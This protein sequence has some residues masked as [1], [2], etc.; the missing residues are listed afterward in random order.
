MDGSDRKSVSSS[1][2]STHVIK[3]SSTSKPSASDENYQRYSENGANPPPTKHF[4]SPTISAASK[5]IAP[6]KKILT[7]RNEISDTRIQK[8]LNI[9]SKGTFSNPDINNSDDSLSVNDDSSPLPRPKFLRYKPNRG[10]EIILR[11]ENV[12]E[13]EKERSTTDEVTESEEVD[14]GEEGAEEEEEEEDEEEEEREGFC[15]RVLKLL[16][17]LVVLVLSTMCISSSNSPTYSQSTLQAM[18][19]LRD[20]YLKIHDRFLNSMNFKEIM[21]LLEGGNEYLDGNIIGLMKINQTVIYKGVEEEEEIVGEVYIGKVEEI[22]EFEFEDEKGDGKVYMGESVEILAGESEEVCDLETAKTGEAVDQML[23]N[24]ELE[25]TE[26]VEK[27]ELLLQDNQIPILTNVA[28][29]QEDE[30]AMAAVQE[31]SMGAGEGLEMVEYEMEKTENSTDKDGEVFM[32]EGMDSEIT[33]FEILNLEG[34]DSLKEER[35]VEHIESEI[36]LKAVIGVTLCFAIVAS[37]VSAF[38]LMRKRNNKKKKDYSSLVM[39]PH[40][41]ESG[42]EEKRHS[43]SP[44]GREQ[45]DKQQRVDDC[46]ASPLTLINSTPL[47]D[48]E[49]SSQT[50]APSIELLGEFVVGELSSSFRSRK[51][52]E[53]EVS[54]HSVSLDN[55]GFL[56][57]KTTFSV[58]TH[59]QQLDFSEASSAIHPQSY[60][61]FTP[62]KKV[63]SKKEE[64]GTGID[65]E[66]K[67][68]VVTTPLRRSSRLRSRVTSP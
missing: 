37:L 60:G 32:L 25:G 1:S 27:L 15:R 67:K 33:N 39:K 9:C 56:R 34:E 55:K 19:G 22:S 36:I 62:E 4:M 49:E 61:Y 63:V 24:F 41:N 47:K 17:V 23:E 42:V 48:A 14:E 16:L 58:P 30:V 28:L 35:L 59:A 5:A 52:I 51:I 12:V 50:R 11:H 65:G 46:F 45:H 40:N 31:N 18:G 66:S 26:S 44:N 64:G 7:E 3:P 43:I 8:T 29:Q 54:S 2:S 20:G 10:R 38:R 13:G 68:V 21:K 57:S 6:R 53:S